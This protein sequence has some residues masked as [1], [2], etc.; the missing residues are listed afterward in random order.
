MQ[1]DFLKY[2]LYLHPGLYIRAVRLHREINGF[3]NLE[4]DDPEDAVVWPSRKIGK[5]Y[6]VSRSFKD[7]QFD[8]IK[9]FSEAT[10]S[11]ADVVRIFKKTDN[12][13]IRVRTARITYGKKEEEFAAII[14][15]SDLEKEGSIGFWEDLEETWISPIKFPP[16]EI[17]EFPPFEN[18]FAYDANY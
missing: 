15:L 17:R 2:Y 3:L 4:E 6:L 16:G 8:L 12:N 10:L 18:L 11:S 13:G 1:K 9:S 5:K 7:F 14:R